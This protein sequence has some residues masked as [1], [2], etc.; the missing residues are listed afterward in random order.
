MKSKFIIFAISAIMLCSCGASANKA[1]N[2]VD[3]DVHKEE[4]A[5]LTVTDAPEA[6]D[7]IADDTYWSEFCEN[8]QSRP[9]GKEVTI[10]ADNTSDCD[11][12]GFKKIGYNFYD[13]R[14][15]FMIP[16][17]W[18]GFRF[19][20]KCEYDCE[21]FENGLTGI[22]VYDGDLPVE[23]NNIGKPHTDYTD[24]FANK[25]M[26]K[27][28]FFFAES[29]WQKLPWLRDELAP[30]YNHETYTDKKGRIMQ[31]YFIDGLPKMAV[32]DDFF[33]LCIWFNVKS[34]DQIPT[35]VNM[36]NSVEVGLSSDAEFALYKA[37][38]LGY[39]IIPPEDE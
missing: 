13:L 2:E 20:P 32:Y 29:P 9:D 18:N 3:Q 5:G 4:P 24:Y 14:Y 8:W 33:N 28:V 19:A 21:Q 12:D 11:Y 35:V 25:P 38:M 6:D 23:I 31:V 27:S 37:E 26:E 16:E 39:T 30:K 10:F 22:P 15:S 7:E 17:D 36:I 34:E 1:A